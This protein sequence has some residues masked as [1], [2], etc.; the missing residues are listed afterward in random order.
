ELMAYLDGESPA[1]ARVSIETHLAGCA[2]CQAAAAE[3]RGVSHRMNGWSVE[4]VPAGLR[5]PRRPH[6]SAIWLPAVPRLPRPFSWRLRSFVISLGGAAVTI[7][8]VANL[9]SHG[10]RARYASSTAAARPADQN[11]IP[12][13]VIDGRSDRNGPALSATLERPPGGGGG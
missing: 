1:D 6:G 4:V 8:L 5:A 7:L 11:G 3:L 13:G 9:A 10:G 12:D 2:E